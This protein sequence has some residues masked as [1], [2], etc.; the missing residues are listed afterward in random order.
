MAGR[1]GR[2]GKKMETQISL[3]MFKTAI[4]NNYC[5]VQNPNRGAQFWDRKYWRDFVMAWF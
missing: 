3:S 1:H 2:K 4:A 5:I